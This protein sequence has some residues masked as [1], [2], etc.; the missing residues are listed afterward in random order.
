[1]CGDFNKTDDARA[2]QLLQ[3]LKTFDCIQHVAE[4][5]HGHT[6]DLVTTRT[7]TDISYL[8]IGGFVSEYALIQFTL[9]AKG[10]SPFLR[11]R[12]AEHGEGCYVTR[13][14]QT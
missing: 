7:D 12:A 13:S 14:L 6:L 3:L 10:R 9:P 1:V 8:R 11:R 4:L 2:V 5:T